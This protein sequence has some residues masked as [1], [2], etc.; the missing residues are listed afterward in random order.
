MATSK[1]DKNTNQWIGGALVFSGRPDPTWSVP[2]LVVSELESYWA[3]L[4]PWVG[5]LPVTPGLGYRGSFLRD[6]SGTEWHGYGG[7][8]TLR[9]S[10]GIQSRQ[11][12]ARQFEK[13]VLATAPAGLLPEEVKRASQ[14][15]K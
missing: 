5:S 6:A 11:D 3:Q 1:S 14:G 15:K 2:D 4:Q 8:L 7:V 9:T 10:K 13:L 12:P